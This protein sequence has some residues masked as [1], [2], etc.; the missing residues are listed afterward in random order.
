MPRPTERGPVS[1]QNATLRAHASR[2]PGPPADA[3][4]L[5]RLRLLLDQAIRC[6]E[7]DAGALRPQAESDGRCPAHLRDGNRE[8][9]A[10]P[11][12]S[13]T[14]RRPSALNRLEPRGPKMPRRE[15]DP[16]VSGP[17]L[18][19]RSRPSSPQP[20]RAQQAGAEAAA[21]AYQ[22]RSKKALISAFLSL[23]IVLALALTL[24]WLRDPLKAVFIKKPAAPLQ[25]QSIDQ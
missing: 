14:T 11:E 13:R 6:A 2:A 20:L 24:Y 10:V 3:Q 22:G 18:R 5:D 25:Q 16:P 1:R 7:G 4:D 19:K 17:H 12:P 21:V 23:L 8:L 15:R 9:E